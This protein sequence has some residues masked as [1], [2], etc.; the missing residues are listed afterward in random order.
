MANFTLNRNKNDILKELTVEERREIKNK[1]NSRMDAIN[2][3]TRST[4]SPRR[5]RALKI[6]VDSS[7][8][9]RDNWD[10]INRISF[11]RL[12]K[13]KWDCQKSEKMRNAQ[14]NTQERKLMPKSVQWRLHRNIVCI[15]YGLLYQ[16]T[17]FKWTGNSITQPYSELLETIKYLSFHHHFLSRQ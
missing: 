17:T 4:Y 10:P 5:E 16:A 2:G 14:M 3:G 1:E 8:K 11:K 15:A 9:K 12:K 13:T 6:Y 7:P